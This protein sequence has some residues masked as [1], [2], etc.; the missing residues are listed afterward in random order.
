MSLA[1]LRMFDRSKSFGGI[2]ELKNLSVVSSLFSQ[3][4]PVR[5]LATPAQ[6]TRNKP[7]SSKPVTAK[8]I[9]K[10][11]KKKDKR[12]P[13]IVAEENS[14]LGLKGEVA[15]VAK[16]YARNYLFPKKMAVYATTDNRNLIPAP[17]SEIIAKREY[18]NAVK[19][20]TATLAKIVIFFK[21]KKVNGKMIAPVSVQNVREKL[22]K[23]QRMLLQEDQ[24][25]LP[26][27]LTTY[28][29]HEIKIIIQST[30]LP[31]KLA[32]VKQ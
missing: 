10:K 24:I 20:A 17:P 31:L 14:T 21:R 22:F 12:I 7:T 3:I 4:Q 25:L 23:Q 13:V 26:Q 15:L 9:T 27:A 6:T 18:E 11:K 19:K 28:G 16:G 2:I 8:Q 1:I 30:E 29:K 32:I 5:L